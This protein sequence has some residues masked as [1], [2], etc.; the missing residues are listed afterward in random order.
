[1]PPEG[2]GGGGGAAVD[3]REAVE[4]DALGFAAV[5]AAAAAPVRRRRVL[6]SVPAAFHEALE[7][8]VVEPE[9]QAA[10]RLRGEDIRTDAAG[11]YR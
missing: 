6:L 4:V 5:A 11:G 10:L 1:M 3:A 9:V 2:R 7:Q 8:G